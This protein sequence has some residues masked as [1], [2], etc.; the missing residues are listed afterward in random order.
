M[1]KPSSES[2]FIFYFV[3]SGLDSSTSTQVVSLLKKLAL[4]GRTIISTIHQPSAIVIG[5][6]DHL[7][8]VAEGKCIFSG[9]T[10]SLIPFL[11]DLDLVCPESYNPTDYR[12]CEYFLFIYSSVLFNLFV[13]LFSFF[14]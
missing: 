3:Y 2:G 13:K 12:K 8:A 4:E 5:M 9:A 11:R 6:F 10:N 14:K 1:H 7:Y